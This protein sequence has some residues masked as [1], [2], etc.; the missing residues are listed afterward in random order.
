MVVISRVKEISQERGK[1]SF[2]SHGHRLLIEGFTE[3][4]YIRS[5]QDS[6]LE[7]CLDLYSDEEITKY[8]DNG[9]PRTAQQILEYIK[10]RGRR[11][12]DRGE[13]FGLFSVFLK[14]SFTFIG[15]VD[16]VPTGNPGEV[17]IGWIF[18]KDFHNKGYCTEAVQ[19]FLLPLIQG[20]YKRNYQS[21]G[22]T[23]NRIIAT[24]HPKNIASNKIIQKAG[25]AFYQS[26][27]RY[28]GNP[29]NWYSLNLI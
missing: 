19:D 20:L 16:L 7:S 29:R 10:E 2:F 13:P 15:Q 3:R 27:L 1:I 22:L 23:I 11:Y 25:L 4:L 26:S 17:E 8:F 6:D 28:E 14:D 18:L 5:Y 24:A 9:K 12:F 21:T